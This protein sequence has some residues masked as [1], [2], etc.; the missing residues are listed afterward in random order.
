MNCNCM[1][2]I[3]IAAD[4]KKDGLINSVGISKYK[5]KSKDALFNSVLK[6]VKD[7]KEVT[8]EY[9]SNKNS[10]NTKNVSKDTEHNKV[11]QYNEF[12]EKPDSNYANEEI[13]DIEEIL[14]LDVNTLES[15]SELLNI[16]NKLVAVLFNAV[17]IDIKDFSIEEFNV[18]EVRDFVEFV[19][20]LTNHV[21]NDSNFIDQL[22]EIRGCSLNLMDGSND[23]ENENENVVETIEK[24]LILTKDIV[25]EHHNYSMFNKNNLQISDE[26]NN[27]SSDDT[28]KN[29]N[30][31]SGE[32]IVEASHPEKIGEKTKSNTESNSDNE[33]SKNTNEYKLFY[34]TFDDNKVK[35]IGESNKFINKLDKLDFDQY[36]TNSRDVDNLL[37]EVAQ[38]TKFILKENG[39]EIKIQL[40][41][42]ILGKM[43]LKISLEKGEMHAKALVDNTQAKQL[44]DNNLTQLKETLKEQGIE[45][46]TFEVFVGKDSNFNSRDR[47]YWNGK[48]NVK[49][50]KT[51]ID[52]YDGVSAYYL[53]MLDNASNAIIVRTSSFDIKA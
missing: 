23:I 31:V 52:E 5:I 44:I 42:E 19:D 34:N 18:N 25:K 1:E 24:L 9:K 2:F 4:L 53:N 38:K 35:D 28:A 50:K 14:S 29:Q 26:I 15:S 51:N 11:K 30:R 33:S 43:I 46:K 45:V 36:R 20:K 49:I 6:A 16:L 27:I 12:R 22:M 7:N 47:K 3:D 21:K 10:S 41:P 32:V 8:T 13:K 40:K 48:P 37:K 39:S 17:D